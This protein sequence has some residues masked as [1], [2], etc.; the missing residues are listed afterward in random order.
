MNGG[1]KLASNVVLKNLNIMIDNL[2]T[3]ACQS[4]LTGS[5]YITL[6]P[7]PL[8]MKGTRTLGEKS[9]FQLLE[10]GGGLQLF[11]KSLSVKLK[12]Y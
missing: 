12:G 7:D 8:I 3:D 6:D 10:S 9:L 11:Q 1:I 5:C 4:I 2:V